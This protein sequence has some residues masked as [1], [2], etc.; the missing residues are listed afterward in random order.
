MH[1]YDKTVIPLIESN[2]NTFTPLEK[3]IAAFFIHNRES[4][5]FSSKAIAGQLFV[6]EASLSRFAQK[7]GFK[8]YR[9]FIY[10]YKET[11]IPGKEAVTGNTR[12]VLNTYQELL[13]KAYNLV[14]EEQ[15]ARIAGYISEAERVYV[16]GKGSSG[17]AAQET[18]FRFM[19]IGVDINAINDSDIMRMQAVLSN[20]DDV[21]FGFSISGEKQSVLY[22]LRE[23]HARGATTILLTA[24]NGESFGEF[25]DEVVLIPSLRHLNHGNSISPQFPLLVMMDILYS[26]YV[27]QDALKNECMHDTTLR[28][29]EEQNADTF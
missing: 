9:E 15:M 17:L 20:R 2:F 22:F 24:N 4:R 11:F 25:C 29:L 26:Y 7:C 12:A 8:G 13:N 6:S 18:G 19:R 3:T 10:R 28:A 1:Y 21:V 5:D 27:G 14:D 23:A 16:C